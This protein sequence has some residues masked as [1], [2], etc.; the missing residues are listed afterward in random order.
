MTLPNGRLTGRPFA[1]RTWAIAL[2]TCVSVLSPSPSDGQGT[3]TASVDTASVMT[4]VKEEAARVTAREA[5]LL[6]SRCG[7][8]E[9]AAC[10]AA[11]R[12]P[13]TI[14][15][16]AARQD[17]T[18]VS[19]LG[20]TKERLSMLSGKEIP[21]CPWWSPT[22]VGAVGYVIGVDIAPQSRDSV[23]VL[24]HRKCDNPPGYMHD[25]FWSDQRYA[26][27]RTGGRWLA[28]LVETTG[29]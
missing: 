16:L 22:T 10:S 21:P 29:G 3:A 18:V 17:S 7:E 11:R 14:I 4:A 25:V 20:G 6:Q 13:A 15:L 9:S 12:A 5:A 28:S 24:V 26:V 27:V 8:G 2:G 23:E 19:L 1:F